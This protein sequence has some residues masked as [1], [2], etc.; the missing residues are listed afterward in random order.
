MGYRT[1]GDL[2]GQYGQGIP[3]EE[4]SIIGTFRDSGWDFVGAEDGPSDLWAMPEGGGPPILWWEL[5]SPPQLPSFS[6]GDGSPDDPFR[7]ISASDII[8]IGCNPRLMDK[9]YV[10]TNDIDLHDVDY[11]AIGD[12]GYPFVGELDGAGHTLLNLTHPL[13][14]APCSVGLVGYLGNRGK[15]QN[16]HA[17][18][19]NISGNW[20]VGGLVGKTH[21]GT[22]W[23]CGVDGAVQIIDSYQLDSNEYPYQS[24]G[25]LVGCNQM[26]VI[27][28]SFSQVTVVGM[29]YNLPLGGLVGL[30]LS[31]TVSMPMHEERHLKI[32]IWED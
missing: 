10:I 17:V 1:D 24:I 19:V 2:T 4:M 3:T 29:G 16:L 18:D 30:N 32:L 28:D 8:S 22:I 20:T 14:K 25:G 7:I 6:G 9:Q 11:Y 12:Y 31:G 23:Q 26:G 5:N 21:S 13:K 15:I 27:S